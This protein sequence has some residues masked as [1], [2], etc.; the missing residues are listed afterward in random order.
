MLTVTMVTISPTRSQRHKRA[1]LVEPGQHR[2]AQIVHAGC[3]HHVVIGVK[4]VTDDN[5][6][7]CTALKKIVNYTNYSTLR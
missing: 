2:T 3:R 1:M 4:Q 5:A 6:E 7:L